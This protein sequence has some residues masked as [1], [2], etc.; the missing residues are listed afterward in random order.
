[1]KTKSKLVFQ[2]DIHKRWEIQEVVN[3]GTSEEYK[4][5]MG[6]IESH[7]WGF[8]WEHTGTLRRSGSSFPRRDQALRA[9]KMVH[10]KY[11]NGLTLKAI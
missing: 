9:L 2:N 10:T 5:T 11:K 8:E 1:M 4:R 3:A 6:I 7:V